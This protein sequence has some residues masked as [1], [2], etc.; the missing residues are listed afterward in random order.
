MVTKLWK[1]LNC[2]TPAQHIHLCDP[3]YL[4]IDS[5]YKG[6][7]GLQTLIEWANVA[8]V[9][10][11]SDGTRIKSFTKDTSTTLQWT[12]VGLATLYQFLLTLSS[13]TSALDFSS[14]M[15]LGTI[16]DIFTGHL[17][18]ITLSQ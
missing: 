11:T 4:P 3:D 15:I 8:S 2:K 1:L 18:A 6:Q 12:C 7:R 16:S 14:K 9:I 13:P 17:A 10:S 5:R